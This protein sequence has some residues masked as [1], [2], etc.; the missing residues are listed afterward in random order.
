[1]S[2]YYKNMCHISFSI[3]RQLKAYAECENHTER[4]EILWHEWNHNKRWL[5]QVQQLIL[6][7]FPAYSLHDV[8]HS[9][10]VLHNIEMLM[11]EENIR[12]LSATDCFLILHTVY[13]HDIGMCITH[14]DREKIL[15]NGKFHKFLN[16][17]LENGT[18]EMQRY[19]QI[20]LQQCIPLEDVSDEEKRKYILKGK[21]EIY[22]ALIC[23]LAEYRR[24]EHGD[25]SRDHLVDWITEPG[26]LGI[27]FSTMDI[28]N[29]L[30]YTIANCANTH[31]KWD[32][33]AVMELHQEDTGFA[34][35]YIHP[36]FV[37]V[38]LQLGDALDMDNNRFHPLSK[39]YWG[40]IS[41]VSEVHYGKHQAMRRLRITNQKISISADCKN[42]DELRLVRHEC[43]GIRSILEKSSYYW[44]VIR[45]KEFNIGLPTF[46]KAELLLNGEKIPEEL[47]E[48][49]FEISQEKA[50]HLLEG[51]NIYIDETFVFLRELL[52]NAVD[53]TKLQFF[54]EYNRK[55]WIEDDEK[56]I[57]DAEMQSPAGIKHMLSPLNYPIHISLIMAKCK[58]NKIE[59]IRP[60]DLSNPKK[61]LKDYQ[62]G[63][64]V[65][66][67][68]YGTGIS[69]EDIAQIANVGSSYESR[70]EEINKMP[71]WLQP[72]GAF[73]IGLQSAFLAGNQ[74]VANTFTR[75]EESY[76]IVFNP[77]RKSANGYINVIPNKN[78]QDDRKSYG[79][80]FDIFVPNDK[81]KL[82]KESQETWDG[83]DPFEEGYENRRA[84]RH[85]RELIKQMA[86][87]LA[88]MIGEPLFPIYLHIRDAYEVMQE[89]N[90]KFKSYY[91]EK[92]ERSFQESAVC[93]DVNGKKKNPLSPKISW[94]YDL[95]GQV[96][97]TE[98]NDAYFLDIKK[99]KLFIWNQR[100]NAYAC[101]GIGRILR[102]R[103]KVNKEEKDNLNIGTK[104]F[105]KGIMVAEKNF[106]ED[107]DLVEYIDLKETLESKF[108]KLNRNGFSSQ[109]YQYLEK[110]YQA[111]IC[112]ARKVLTIIGKE[113]EELE[114]IQTSIESLLKEKKVE[115]A[116]YAILS[117]TALAYFAMAQE[118][119]CLYGE[120][121]EKGSEN[122]NLLL[123]EISNLKDKFNS[124]E[125]K[126]KVGDS[127]TLFKITVKNENCNSSTMDEKKS[128]LDIINGKN[129]YAILSVREEKNHFW[130]E[131]MFDIT[132][133]HGRLKENIQRLGYTRDGKERWKIMKELSEM[134]SQYLNDE[135][136]KTLDSSDHRSYAVIHKEMM[137][138]KW[139]LDN[140]PTMA[141]FTDITGNVRLNILDTE[142]SDTV[143]Y[144]I[145]MRFL[146]LERMIQIYD[147]RHICRF[148]TIA[149]SGY[150]KL[151]VEENGKSILPVNRGKMS[152]IG[153]GQM[154]FP[155]T[156]SEIEE[157]KRYIEEYIEERFDNIYDTGIKTIMDYFVKND[158]PQ[159]QRKKFWEKAKQEMER[160]LN[161]SKDVSD[162]VSELSEQEW[163]NLMDT[164][165]V[166]TNQVVNADTEKFSEEK[167]KLFQVLKKV[168][169]LWDFD[170]EK[171]DKW[172]KEYYDKKNM[173]FCSS[174]IKFVSEHSKRGIK[175]VEIRNL[176]YEFVLETGR[177][178][179][180]YEKMEYTKKFDTNIIALLEC[181]LE[182]DKQMEI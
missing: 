45:P 14:Q 88:E 145:N 35:D 166:C 84:I 9:E 156:G 121:N 140:I 175:E 92:F 164:W 126:N 147:E 89:N 160:E 130:N 103:E 55:M 150:R 154:I 95:D 119:E 62:C 69:K 57:N 115:V 25:I 44:S 46:D 65:K 1:M 26:K 33:D 77:R 94:A 128:V 81:K 173:Q 72:T 90:E 153:R 16:K 113:R 176:Y 82:H 143:Y 174:M 23:L 181:L 80:C 177:V 152:Y 124:N 97:N 161:C 107:A 78:L 141:V 101:L 136:L 133:V 123:D 27:G 22:Y 83:T 100:Y 47:V 151:V 146:L 15:E 11:G 127:S 104:I 64:W 158:I 39:E 118:R 37:A 73:G 70:Q 85:T 182:N 135:D 96:K 31:T 167:K 74:L 155:L 162:D 105:Y 18:I 125:E 148:S 79:T 60:E 71:K 106:Q 66:I 49:R 112:T 68:D 43:D 87:Y 2:D 180:E 144:D 17:I 178:I 86:F 129:K 34:H 56:R 4:H 134:A 122:W 58:G 53:A 75:K 63:V 117:F 32:F 168:S 138:M 171:N 59:Q 8:T 159:D 139:F 29:R 108:L 131:Y 137:I 20:L 132:N 169:G 120:Y 7:S 42:Q 30:F 172:L 93:V 67:K 54:R 149:W 36:R 157:M 40:A 91:D 28:P 163:K 21:L 6:P 24:A 102:M 170:Y 41:S 13:V 109:G 76:E 61:Q 110:V 48:T 12:L 116:E 111:I 114:K 5:T 3:E 51:N 50:F 38:M 179:F 10:S 19:A 165:K 98:E 52:Q 99:M 142:L